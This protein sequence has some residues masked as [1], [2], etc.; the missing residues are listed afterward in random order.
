MLHLVMIAVF[1]LQH[2]T[3]TDAAV[4]LAAHDDYSGMRTPVRIGL[5]SANTYGKYRTGVYC[6]ASSRVIF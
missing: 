3:W 2:H 1:L 4:L 5:H 6:E